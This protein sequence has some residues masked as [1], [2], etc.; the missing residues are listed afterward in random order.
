MRPYKP[1]TPLTPV[2]VIVTYHNSKV[3]HGDVHRGGG[4]GL[5]RVER[6]GCH[7]VVLG[8]GLGSGVCLGGVVLLLQ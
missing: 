8:E 5:V 6:I 1:S 3:E 7:Q 2:L 4:G